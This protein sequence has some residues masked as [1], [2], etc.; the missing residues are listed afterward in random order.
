VPQ[1][2]VADDHAG[3]LDHP[4]VLVEVE[5]RVVRPL[6]ELLERRDDR[7]AVVDFGPSLQ[8]VE[9]GQITAPCRAQIR[10]L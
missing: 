2:R 7:D 4:R 10:E 3:V 6:L 1:P 5:V 9:R 8:R